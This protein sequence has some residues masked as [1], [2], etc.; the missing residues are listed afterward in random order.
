MLDEAT[1]DK[2]REVLGQATLG[3]QVLRTAACSVQTRSSLGSDG[4]L[5]VTPT[6]VL[7]V[8]HDGLHGTQVTSWSRQGLADAVLRT[9]LFGPELT[10]R[11]DDGDEI[12][13]TGFADEGDGPA[14]VTLL[15]RAL[16]EVPLTMEPQL[17]VR[18]IP[19]EAP[20]SEAAPPELARVTRIRAVLVLSGAV[21]VL[22][23]GM[24]AA[25]VFYLL[26][27]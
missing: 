10:L 26:A 22:M 7:F 21:A 15:D 12:T 16:D 11:T 8:A 13:A 2:L 6:R 17:A 9:D 19:T 5:G 27:A 14:L 24:L 1:L 23:M 20:P 25:V 4:L 3:E 18:S